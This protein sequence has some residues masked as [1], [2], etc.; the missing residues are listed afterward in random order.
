[1]WSSHS[2][3]KKR[4]ASHS[5]I[6][7]RLSWKNSRDYNSR[8]NKYKQKNVI[9][10][11]ISNDW[12]ILWNNPKITLP[13]HFL[14]THPLFSSAFELLKE[15]RAQHRCICNIGLCRKENMEILS[16]Q[17]W[18][19]ILVEVRYFLF[20]FTY[21]EKSRILGSGARLIFKKKPFNSK[22]QLRSDG[23]RVHVPP[24]FLLRKFVSNP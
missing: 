8:L 1:M 2:L 3:L 12:L 19:M 17:G 24:I 4:R 7:R 14:L 23:I 6:K 11:F 10:A 18:L 21:R 15:G 22:R 5:S 20:K 9:M 13:I 16:Y